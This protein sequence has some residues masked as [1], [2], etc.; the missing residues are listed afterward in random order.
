M[1]LQKPILRVSS[2]R[3]SI[4]LC[5][6]GPSVSHPRLTWQLCVSHM[7]SGMSSQVLLACTMSHGH[8]ELQKGLRNVVFSWM[9]IFWLKWGE[10]CLT[11]GKRTGWINSFCHSS[12][13]IQIIANAMYH[14]LCMHL[15][16]CES[17]ILWLL[18][19]CGRLFAGLSCCT[20]LVDTQIL[21][22]MTLVAYNLRTLTFTL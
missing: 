10:D 6:I 14:I 11:I 12:I 1:L 3:R 4:P 8:R 17:Y 5:H 19:I 7:D 16:V 13:G 18:H 22:K 2:V 9:P 20:K 15:S 21:Y